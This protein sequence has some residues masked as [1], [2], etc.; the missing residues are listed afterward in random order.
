VTHGV[1]PAVKEV[2]TPD[3]EAIRDR[4]PVEAQRPQLGPNHHAMLPSGNFGQR[5]VGCAELT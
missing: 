3:L 2:E 1:N 4:V 5:N